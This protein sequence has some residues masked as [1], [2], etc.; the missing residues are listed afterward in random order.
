[1]VVWSDLEMFEDGDLGGVEMS[2][3]DMV[4]VLLVLDG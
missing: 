1:M 2:D 4:V 3:G